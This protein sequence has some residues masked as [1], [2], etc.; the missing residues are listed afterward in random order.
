MPAI[1]SKDSPAFPLY[2][3][4]FDVMVENGS[5]ASKRPAVIV[6]NNL[7]NEYSNTVSVLPMMSKNAGKIYSFEVYVPKG[8]AGLTKDSRIQA[9]Q[10]RTIDKRRLV[11]FHGVLPDDILK[12]VDRALKVHLNMRVY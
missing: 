11:T 8:T 6:S 5:K 12:Q 1:K 3:D 10:V 9:D 2:G 7:N 4:V